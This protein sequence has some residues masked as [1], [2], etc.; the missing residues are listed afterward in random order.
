MEVKVSVEDYFSRDELKSIVEDEIRNYVYTSVQRYFE[1]NTYREFVE[2]VAL[3]AYWEAVEKLGE[4]TMAKVRWQVRKLIPEL[5]V[6]SLIDTRYQGGKEVPTHVQEV[7]DDE[8]EKMRPEIA[9]RIRAA[10]RH[11]IDGDGPGIVA[12]TVED[13]LVKALVG[14]ER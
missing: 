5:S 10:Y 1:H 7:I 11:A 9:E 6:Y 8:A 2:G 4:D 12:D 13:V 14:G 3:S